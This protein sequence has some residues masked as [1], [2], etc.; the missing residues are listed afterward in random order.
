MS[1]TK[2]TH[3]QLKPNSASG[4]ATLGA[5]RALIWAL[6]ILFISLPSLLPASELS[7]VLKGLSPLQRNFTASLFPSVSTAHIPNIRGNWHAQ[8]NT[9]AHSPDPSQCQVFVLHKHQLLFSSLRLDPKLC[10]NHDGLA[11]SW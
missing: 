10:F 3:V 7:S 1:G 6:S 9:V 8:P 4:L 5:H 2:C 11:A